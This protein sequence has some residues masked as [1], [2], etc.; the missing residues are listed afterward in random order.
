MKRQPLRRCWRHRGNGRTRAFAFQ[1]LLLLI[2][3]NRG[4]LRNSE[5]DPF[6]VQVFPIARKALCIGG[7][8]N[9]RLQRRWA[10]IVLCKWGGREPTDFVGGTSLAGDGVLSWGRARLV[11]HGWSCTADGSRM[12]GCTMGTLQP[13]L[14][15]PSTPP[16]VSS[17][18]R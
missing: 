10:F 5:G 16:V 14:T 12:S 17:S 15:V 6:E 11:V 18:S 2:P 3:P 4:V 8:Y 9:N 7:V 1:Q 13:T